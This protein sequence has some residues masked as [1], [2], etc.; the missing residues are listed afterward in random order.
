MTYCGRFDGVR[1][2]TARKSHLMARLLDRVAH[3]FTP[4]HSLVYIIQRIPHTQHYSPNTVHPP[5]PR[6]WR[7]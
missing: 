3:T 6:F 7:P 5:G 4:P 1:C 2:G